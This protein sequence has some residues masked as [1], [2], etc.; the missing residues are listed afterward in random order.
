VKLGPVL[1]GDIMVNVDVT[2]TRYSMI[3]A[4]MGLT[5]NSWLV[6]RWYPVLNDIEVMI[7]WWLLICF[8]YL[9]YSVPN[10]VEVVIFWWFLIWL[11]YVWYPF[12]NDVEV[13][14]FWWFLI[15]LVYVWYP[16]PNDAGW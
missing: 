11:V 12:S 14:R 2:I 6:Y 7:F 5:M 1:L 3:C 4:T 15:W 8:V 13:V 16:F 9:W 10:D